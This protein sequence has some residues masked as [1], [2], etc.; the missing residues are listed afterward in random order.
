MNTAV[1]KNILLL[2]AVLQPGLFVALSQDLSAFE[3]KWMV[4]GND[5]MPYRVLLPLNY[6]TAK[7]YPV[8]FFLHGAG[9]RGRD[10]EKQLV[11]GSK[12][13]LQEEVRKNF[14]AIVVFPQCGTNDYWSNV[15]RTHD[16]S[17]KR[18][19]HF[20]PGGEPTRSMALLQKLTRLIL[21]SYRVK[22]NQVYI[23][24]LSM[25]AMGTYELV[26]RMPRIFAAA[27]AICGGAEPSTARQ[28]KQT[29]WWIFHG[30][31][32]D[33]VD[34]VFS[35]KMTDAL[36]AAGADTRL[37]LYPEANHNSWDPAFAEKELFTWLFSKKKK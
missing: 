25:G 27:F 29:S 16:A 24:G 37:T 36:K 12:L 14:P 6:D 18:Q 32:D 17:G 9:E 35:R 10:N 21:A 5:T 7:A 8:I 3:K 22:S 30:L 11:H 15:L 20:L 26:R 13:F 4:Q 1:L 33:V 23:G 34:P 19:F 31:K 2:F 28:L